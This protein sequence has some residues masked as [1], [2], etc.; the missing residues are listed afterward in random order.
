M[1]EPVA[2][3]LVDMAQVSFAWP[4]TPEFLRIEKFQVER[5][6]RVFIKGASGSGKSTLL[7]LIG[8]VLTQ[9]SGS[10]RVLGQ[11]LS[12]LSG[13]QRDAFRAAHLGFIF[14]MFNLIPYLSMLD[15]VLLAVRFCE[16]RL[17]RVTTADV[18]AEARRL[19]KG[20]GLDD[21]LHARQV[22][23]LSMG[24]QQRVAAAR[25]LLGRPQLI[26]ADEPTSS[27]D[28]AARAD[29]LELLLRECSSVDA[30]IVFVSHDTSLGTLFDRTVQMNEVNKAAAVAQV[31]AA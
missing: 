20:L 12:D 25:A 19:L 3:F 28:T 2:P 8:G 27:L 24:Q 16:Q 6:E 23:Q 31:A 26:I 11:E 30:A 5:G 22:T 4:H 21:E 13:G 9:R 14:Q 17:R 18:R 15:N 7:G 29:F 1:K 10:I